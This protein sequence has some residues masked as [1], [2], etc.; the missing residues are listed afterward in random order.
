MLNADFSPEHE[1]K[2]G[3][4]MMASFFIA[5]KSSS[6]CKVASR[7]KRTRGAESGDAANVQ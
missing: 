5:L 7:R 1:K 2:L 4:R 3:N 6:S